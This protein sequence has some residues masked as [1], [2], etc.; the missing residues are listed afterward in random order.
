MKRLFCNLVSFYF[1]QKFI[2]EN[3]EPIFQGNRGAGF[4]PVFP[5]AH[6]YDQPAD[7]EHN[8][9]GKPHDQVTL[10][11]ISVSP[12]DHR[13][14]RRD[15]QPGDALRRDPGLGHRRPRAHRAPPARG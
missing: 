13:R 3:K 14:L 11:G 8:A 2:F 5:G 6:E 10:F 7:G 1:L 4:Y 9:K 15:R 12:G